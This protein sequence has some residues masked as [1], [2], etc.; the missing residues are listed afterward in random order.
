M[1]PSVAAYL[2][3]SDM[4]KIGIVEGKEDEVWER[5]ESGW[6]AAIVSSQ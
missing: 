3:S 4:H 6:Q 1:C 2:N 5:G